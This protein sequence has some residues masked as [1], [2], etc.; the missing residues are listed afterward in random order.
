MYDVAIV[1]AGPIG[2]ELAAALQGTGLSW[3]HF[4]AGQI[5]STLGWWAPQTRFFSSPER[6]AIAGVPLVTIDQSKAT[7]EEYLAYLR[8]VVQLFGL[9][10][11]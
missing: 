1:G 4:E 10:I 5:G 3:V 9:E 7:R 6:I 11:A 8:G 2:I